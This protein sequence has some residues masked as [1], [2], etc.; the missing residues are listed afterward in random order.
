M[1]SDRLWFKVVSW[2]IFEEVQIST[3]VAL[4]GQRRPRA[5][6]TLEPR[7]PDNSK[8]CET[9]FRIDAGVHR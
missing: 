2:H 7:V 9:C 3:V 1:M 5:H 4:C 8:T 6:T